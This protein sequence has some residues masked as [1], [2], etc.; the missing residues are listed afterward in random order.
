[1]LLGGRNPGS[2]IACNHLQTLNND[3][4]HKTNFFDILNDPNPDPTDPTPPPPSIN[5]LFYDTTSFYSKYSNQ[6]Q[7][8]IASINIQ[9]LAS[10]HSNLAKFTRDAL[11]SKVPLNITALQETWSIHYPD[12]LSINNL[13]LFLYVDLWV[14]GEEGLDFI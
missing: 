7:H 10:K 8:I 5:S 2:N 14:V 3:P 11:N 13:N 12:L 9:S 6:H 1:M 4:A